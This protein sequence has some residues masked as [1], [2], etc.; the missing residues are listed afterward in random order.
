MISRASG[1]WKLLVVALC[2]T[3]LRM[4]GAW[5]EPATLE[6]M[7]RLAELA[8]EGDGDALLTLAAITEIDGQPVDMETILMG[9]SEV[10]QDRLETLAALPVRAEARQDPNQ[11]R[12]Q[13]STILA[14]DRFR[15]DVDAVGRSWLQRLLSRLDVWLPNLSDWRIWL[16]AFAIVVAIQAIYWRRLVRNRALG[17]GQATTSGGA[18]PSGASPA[19]LD[20]AATKAEAAGDFSSAVRLRFRAALIRLEARGVIEQ[21]RTQ[22][23]GALRRSMRSPTVDRLATTFERVAY[24]GRPAGWAEA[25]EARL[26]WDQVLAGTRG[27]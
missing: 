6:E 25:T 5:G 1:R 11:A 3:V 2:M 4:G 16:A 10:I 27:G 15:T 23:A 26:G 13:A 24:G 8:A 18:A 17:I 9:D 20:R 7:R 12:Q 21:E 19:D 14:Q 22:T